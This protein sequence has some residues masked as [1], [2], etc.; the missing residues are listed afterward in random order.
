MVVAPVK[1]NEL[2]DFEFLVV[3][4]DLLLEFIGF[5]LDL[6]Y[7]FVLGTAE[8]SVELVLS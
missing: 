6:V 7:F 1:I 8:I 4:L 2:P 3:L 5:L